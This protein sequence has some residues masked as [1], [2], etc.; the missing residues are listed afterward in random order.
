MSS[1][2]SM[3]SR[4]GLLLNLCYSIVPLIGFVLVEAIYGLEAGVIVAVILS[5]LE[6]AWV[7]W[8]ERR[9]EPFAIWSAVLIVGM[10]ALS[11]YTS[12]DVILL[13]KPAIFEG[14]FALILLFSSLMGKPFIMV[15]ARKQFGSEDMFNDF[16][17]EYFYGV[18][19][20]LGILFLLHTITIIYSAF[21]LSNEM[22]LLNVG[23]G[24][25]IFFA[26]FF[27]GEFIYSRWR[28]KKQ[29]EYMSRQAAF[30]EHQRNIIEQ[31]KYSPREGEQKL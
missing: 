15:V 10:G 14:I 29:M 31:M 20:R 6:V 28:M 3:P 22:Y 21:Y 30:L 23:A 16:Q 8:R 4:S 13:L 25:Y 17:K 27:V 5:L 24:F 1:N 7:Y 19:W 12:N 26:V 18:N 2:P 11:W 9:W